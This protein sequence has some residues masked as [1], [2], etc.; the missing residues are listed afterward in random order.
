[1]YQYINIAH[2]TAIP[3]GMDYLIFDVSEVAVY[4]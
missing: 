1:M 2:K 3:I 4:I